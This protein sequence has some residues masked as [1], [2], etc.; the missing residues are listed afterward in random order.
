MFQKLEPLPAITSVQS[1]QSQTLSENPN[2]QPQSKINTKPSE[3]DIPKSNNNNN[4]FQKPQPIGIYNF[5]SNKTHISS[6][7]QNIDEIVSAFI[8]QNRNNIIKYVA[9]EVQKKLEEKIAPMTEEIS[10]LKIEF[11]SL[12]EEEWND[13]K[14]SNVLNDCHNN[15][16]EL[17]NKM[18]IMNENIN[19]YNDNIKGFNIA[20]NRL[21]FLNKLNK[22]LD[23]FISGIGQ[24]LSSNENKNIFHGMGIMDNSLDQNMHKIEKEMNKQEN[25]NHELDNVFYETMEMLKDIT[26]DDIL[27]ENKNNMNANNN[28]MNCS[29]ILN[30]F[31]NTVNAFNTKFNYEKPI[32]NNSISNMNNTSNDHYKNDI[33]NI[34]DDLPNF[35]D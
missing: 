20:D 8:E 5:S 27:E 7:E 28:I 25:L 13:F 17:D 22:D 16:M 18:N 4:I 31:E 33:K 6:L 12:Y 29:D 11:N 34:L 24:N 23:E 14:E 3:P 32:N 19:K 9:Q 21:Q 30:N 35:F 26:K 2:S 1:F 15:I 10:K